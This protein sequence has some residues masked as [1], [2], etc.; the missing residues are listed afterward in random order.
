MRIAES[1][2]DN[3]TGDGFEVGGDFSL[4]S[5]TIREENIGVPRT[6]QQVAV[7]DEL[8]SFNSTSTLFFIGMYDRT[9]PDND[10]IFSMLD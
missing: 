6:P 4:G 9:K 7:S 8:L 10:N 3:G 5:R 1:Y 2:E